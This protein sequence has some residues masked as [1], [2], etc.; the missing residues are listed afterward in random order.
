MDKV[1]YI[2]QMVKKPMRVDGKM[3]IFINME[4]YIMS[5]KQ[6]LKKN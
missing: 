1:H 5:L 2:I 6:K 3:E 4:F